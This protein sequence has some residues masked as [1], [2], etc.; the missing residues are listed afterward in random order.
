MSVIEKGAEVFAAEFIYPEAEFAQDISGLGIAEWQ[1][2][3]VVTFKRQ[4]QAKISYQF[5]CKR[6][7]WLRV[8]APGQFDG[9]QFQ[10]LEDDMFGTPFYR[11]QNG[12]SRRL[13]I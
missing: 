5:I 11:R 13:S 1:G 4:C 8:I 7:E 10:K 2:R 6:L 9:V 12:T 3:D